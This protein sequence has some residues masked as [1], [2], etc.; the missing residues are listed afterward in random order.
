MKARLIR[1]RLD[2]VAGRLYHLLC[3][4]AVDTNQV[5]LYKATSQSR[6][7]GMAVGKLGGVEERAGNQ[8]VT[9]ENQQN[10]VE[11]EQHNNDR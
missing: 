11:L 10:S 8:R 6:G 2:Q 1:A 4:S 7:G 5:H 3:S 9:S